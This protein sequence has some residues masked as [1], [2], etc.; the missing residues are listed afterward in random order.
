M[1][2]NRVKI[3]IGSSSEGRPV[4]EL[5]REILLAEGVIATGWWETGVFQVG[6]AYLESLH[7]MVGDFN[8]AVLVATPDDTIQTRGHESR[9]PRGN[10]L[11][12]YGMFSGVH[13]RE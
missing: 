11:L 9:T 2:E 3:F 5:I 13:G 7:R 4:A 1:S 8:C 12:E 6:E 10:V